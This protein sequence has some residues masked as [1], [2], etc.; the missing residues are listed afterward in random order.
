MLG[1]H[2]LSSSWQATN[3]LNEGNLFHFLFQTKK[4]YAK[5]TK[6]INSIIGPTKSID[7]TKKA[8]ERMLPVVDEVDDHRK[9]RASYIV[10]KLERSDV[11]GTLSTK[12]VAIGIIGLREPVVYG[13]PFE[14]AL[15]PYET[16][17]PVLQRELG[18]MF[19]PEG[20]GQGYCTEAVLA[21]LQA[22]QQVENFYS[23]YHGLWVQAVMGP[24]NK[25][26]QRVLEK[27]GFEQCG[28]HKWD[29]PRVFLGGDWQESEVL[30]F[31]KSI[32]L[33]P[34]QGNVK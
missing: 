31:A 13:V 29:G 32:E 21:L 1:Q 5:L 22:C 34:R 16:G 2:S 4:L 27:A 15:S 10:R 25:K 7:D 20:W 24:A 33:F 28:L 9:Y 3:L 17:Y 14:Q 19:L 26:S 6:P 18:Y 23:P 30:L 12:S 8:I 11:I